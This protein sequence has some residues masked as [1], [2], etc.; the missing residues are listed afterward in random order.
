MFVAGDTQ[1]EKAVQPQRLRLAFG[2]LGF[3]G[4]WGFLGLGLRVWRLAKIQATARPDY[5]WPEI[6]SGRS[7]AAKK[8]EKQEWAVEKPK[9]DNAR[10]LKGISF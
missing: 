8:K 1:Q 5:L 7:K 2:V 9:L 10:K 4:F 6:W 3:G